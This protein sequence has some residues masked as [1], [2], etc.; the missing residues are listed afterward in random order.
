MRTHGPV[1]MYTLHSNYSMWIEDGFNFTI[2]NK[3][4]PRLS[5]G[6]GINADPT[7]RD[8]EMIDGEEVVVH[9]LPS[10]GTGGYLTTPRKNKFGNET[11]GC[12]KLLSRHNNISLSALEDDSIIHVHAS[13]LQSK[14]I[15]D[16]GGTVDIV[17]RGKITLQSE[18]E[19]EINAP[20]VDINGTNNVYIDGIRIDLNLPHPPPEL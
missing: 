14:I 3:S 17:A 18:T 1:N 7:G 15:I 20:E 12:V 9:G 16:T 11:T 10:G 8:T 2:E 4:T 5:Y 19:V 13:G 6:P